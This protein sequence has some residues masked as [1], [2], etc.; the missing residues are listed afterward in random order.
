M[1]RQYTGLLL[2]LGLMPGT[3]ASAQADINM[4]THWY[5]RASYNPAFI[6]RTEYLYIFSNNRH[7]WT[8]VEGAPH[9]YNVQVS[10]YIHRLH[11]AVGLSYVNDRIGLTRAS[12]PMLSYA[13]L[14][15]GDPHWSLSLGLSAGIFV[16]S[17]DG[18][19]FEAGTI[20]D[21]S[22][23]YAMERTISPDANTGLEFQSK[24]FIFGI[25][26]THLFS[27]G[28]ADHLLLNANHRYGY[29]I[30]KNNNLDLFYYRAGIMVVNRYNLTVVEGNMLIRFK[31]PTGLLQGPR[32]IFDLGISLR[33]S[34]Q[35]TFLAGLL[36]RPDLR[37]GY[38][39]DHSF[40]GGYNRNATH[41]FMI[42]Y[43]IPT[44]AASTIGRCGTNDIRLDD[45]GS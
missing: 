16:R 40:A 27:I 11:S 39:Y 1:K 29:V 15:S 7:Q 31:H 24:H 9:I 30:Y 10:E 42:E 13:Y 12:N 20:N 17:I 26:A 21:P 22:L 2:L 18:S 36:L 44:K 28:K 19:L 35:M 45:D 23:N 32:E 33:S 5:N 14:I 4:A 34:R 25:S 43:R 6:A 8:G 41:E 3:K 38:A 37:I